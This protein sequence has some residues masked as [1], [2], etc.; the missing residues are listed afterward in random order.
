[1]RKTLSFVIS[2]ILPVVSFQPSIFLND[3]YFRRET[4]LNVGTGMTLD[5]GSQ[6]LVSA[7]K[8]LGLILEEANDGVIV[9][10]ILDGTCQVASAG[11]EIGD[12]LIAVQNVDTKAASIEEVMNQIGK[13]PR[14]VNLR[15]QRTQTKR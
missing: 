4:A 9:A 15:F 10:E 2:M 6:I 5:D 12:Q 14:V 7:Q 1:M 13:A 11:V 3:G 8:P